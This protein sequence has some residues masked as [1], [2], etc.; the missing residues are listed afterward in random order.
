FDHRLDSAQLS[1]VLT[2]TARQGW[3]LDGRRLPGGP[4]SLTLERVAVAAPDLQARDLVVRVEARLQVV[5]AQSLGRVASWLTP[6]REEERSAVTENLVRTVA[7][8]LV[9]S[10]RA[11]CEVPP[12]GPTTGARGSAA[13]GQ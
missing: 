4:Q 6:G 9:R 5:T 2:F 1:Q 13:E 3:T 8:D 10:A 11:W 7:E 12:A